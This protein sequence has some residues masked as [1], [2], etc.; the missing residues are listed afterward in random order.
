MYVLIA[1]ACYKEFRAKAYSLS[2]VLAGLLRFFVV[3]EMGFDVGTHADSDFVRVEYRGA[4]SVPLELWTQHVCVGVA[5]RGVC[6]FN[7]DSTCL[8]E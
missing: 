2:Q 1:N 5:D 8:G 7:V 3:V 4:S 6:D